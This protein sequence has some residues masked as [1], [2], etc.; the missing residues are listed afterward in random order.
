MVGALGV[1]FG[2]TGGTWVEDEQSIYGMT[3]HGANIEPVLQF[4]QDV[5]AHVDNGYLVGLLPRQVICRGRS[6]LAGAEN[7][8]FH[9]FYTALCVPRILHEIKYIGALMRNFAALT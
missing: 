6:N 8:Y 9:Y 2:N 4:A 3:D 1:D 7:Q 5:G